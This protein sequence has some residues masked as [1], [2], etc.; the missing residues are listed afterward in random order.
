MRDK[1]TLAI[2]R[3]TDG[4]YLGFVNF[5]PDEGR[6]IG[7]PLGSKE[8]LTR[9]PKTLWDWASKS[10]RLC[11]PTKKLANGY[12][13]TTRSGAQ[14]ALAAARVVLKAKAERPLPDWAQQALDAGWK[15]PRG[16]RP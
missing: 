9:R 3:D 14:A 7:T 16:W 10:A 6:Y 13:W 12:F 15:M 2:G 8:L 4:Y 11:R 5:D 1:Y